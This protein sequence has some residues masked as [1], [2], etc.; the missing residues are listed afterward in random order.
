MLS[1][2]SD[3]KIFQLI[4]IKNR[5]RLWMKIFG[6][7][8][9]LLLNLPVQFLIWIIASL[10]IEKN[11]IFFVFAC[12]V[13]EKA[14]TSF[15]RRRKWRKKQRRERVPVTIFLLPYQ[16]WQSHRKASVI[17]WHLF[18]RLEQYHTTKIEYE[19]QAWA[20]L[21]QNGEAIIQKI[22][23]KR[24]E[25]ILVVYFIQNTITSMCNKYEN[26]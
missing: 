13:K 2:N 9:K 18:M 24:L 14:H 20:M 15:H 3:I 17:L 5:I 12:S 1:S 10:S 6:P 25:L 26:R 7:Y 23:S 22:K 11:V 4:L 21:P 8:W 19:P 16:V